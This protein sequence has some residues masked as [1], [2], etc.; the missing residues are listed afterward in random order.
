[1]TRRA[2]SLTPS[3]TNRSNADRDSATVASAKSSF[4]TF[5]SCAGTLQTVWTLGTLRTA[6][7]RRPA[8]ELLGLGAKK[9]CQRSTGRPNRRRRKTPRFSL[10]LG[11]KPPEDWAR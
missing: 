11:A 7:A 8:A 2:R 6:V 3:S 4:L 5:T 9:K 10:A 1:M